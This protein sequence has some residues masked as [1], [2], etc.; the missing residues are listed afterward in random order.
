[1]KVT[2]KNEKKKKNFKMQAKMPGSRNK[3]AG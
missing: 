1:M 3:S 2:H